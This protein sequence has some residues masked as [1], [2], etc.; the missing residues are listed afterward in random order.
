LIKD[1]KSFLGLVIVNASPFCKEPDIAARLVVHG[2]ARFEVGTKIFSLLRSLSESP[3]H[4][5]IGSPGKNIAK[6]LFERW[7][8]RW[9]KR[10]FKAGCFF[11]NFVVLA[12]SNSA[13]A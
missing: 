10:R 13:Q 11:K 1:A 12:V 3:I 6:L 7:R 5:A 9:R 4:E 2:E 8:G